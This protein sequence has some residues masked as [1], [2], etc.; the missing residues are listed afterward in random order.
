ML[1]I[2]IWLNFLLFIPDAQGKNNLNS[3]EEFFLNGCLLC[4]FSVMS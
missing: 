1:S 3:R 4:N 2:A